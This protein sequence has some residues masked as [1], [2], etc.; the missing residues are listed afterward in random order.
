MKKIFVVLFLL[1]VLTAV[2][3][4]AVNFS[5]TGNLANDDTVRFFNFSLLAPASVTLRTLSYGGGTNAVGDGIAPGGFDPIITLF[6]DAGNLIAQNDDDGDDGIF[7]GARPDPVTGG[8]FDS[9][10]TF[11]NLTFL[12]PLPAGNYTVAVT[13]FNN[14][15][16]GLNL[17]DG[18]RGA[19][20]VGFIDDTGAKRTSFF[21]LDIL[22]VDSASAVPEP[23]SIML[24]GS[25]LVGFA[26]WRRRKTA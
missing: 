12:T 4:G 9:F 2:P 26:W 5:F 21:A 22:N 24:F 6:G 11:P 17:A 1:Q 10:L 16:I 7:G 19:D 14:F 20:T 23:G 25:G 3:A 15:A 18:F 8:V 13:Q